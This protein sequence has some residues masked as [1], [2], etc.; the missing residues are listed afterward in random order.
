MQPIARPTAAPS[1]KVGSCRET[2]ILDRSHAPPASALGSI[3]ASTGKHTRWAWAVSTFCGAG[4]LKPGP[5][6]WGSAA[7]VALYTLLAFR[8]PAAAR[9]W[10]AAALCALATTIG[11]PA[12]TVVAREAEREDPGFVVIDEVA[13]QA[14]TLI[15]APFAWHYLLAA[16][17]LFRGF[18]ILKPWPVRSLEKLPEGTGIV[19][20]D[21]GAGIY[22]MIVLLLLRHG[23]LL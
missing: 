21:L 11:I 5:G 13:G 1:S 22:A 9:P 16:F 12:A 23:R 20:D 4:L 10:I 15:A 17:L 18:D 2:T 7:T 19:V 8:A 3:G 14:L 6:T